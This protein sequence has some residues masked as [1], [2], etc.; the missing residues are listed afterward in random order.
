[1][2]KKISFV[3]L[4]TAS[5]LEPTAVSSGGLR[6]TF[7]SQCSDQVYQERVRD[8]KLVSA[9]ALKIVGYVPKECLKRF[10][11]EKRY[12]VIE[13]DNYQNGSLTDPQY[14][15]HINSQLDVG[16][17]D[18]SFS[19]SQLSRQ[20]LMQSVRGKKSEADPIKSA[21]GFTT[22]SSD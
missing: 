3:F 10:E 2:F 14:R 21:R 15:D 17:P 18:D 4:T 5:I 12:L 8:R 13:N 9:A 22:I 20:E 1:M 11:E 7:L 6:E 19:A 16:T